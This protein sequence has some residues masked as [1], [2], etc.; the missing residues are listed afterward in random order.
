MRALSLF[1]I[2][3]TLFALAPRVRAEAPPVEFIDQAKELLVVGAC[4]DGTPPASIKPELVKAHCKSVKE[5]QAEYEKRWLSEAKPFFAAHTP[6]SGIPKSVVYPFGGGDLS[7]ALTVF[8]DA[9]EIT[10]LSLEPAGDPRTI[11][12]LDAGAMKVALSKVSTEMSALYKATFSRT[13]AMIDNMRGAQLPTQL[14][15]SL[16]ALAMHGYEP[17]S[18]R[19][20]QL[21]DAGDIHYLNADDLAK[22][23]AIKDFTRRNTELSNMELQY[24]KVG[25]KRVQT[26]RH[27]LANLDDPHL[28]KAPAALHHLEKK[29]HVSAMTK[30]ASFLLAF[31]EFSTM[32]KYL[33][34]HVDWM[35]SDATGLA[36][37]WG[38]PAGFEYETYGTFVR[39]EMDV[40]VSISPSWIAEFKAQPK[41]ELKFR[42][43]Y[44]DVQYHHNLIIMRRSAT[45]PSPTPPTPAKTSPP[46]KT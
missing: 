14:I 33:A 21:T 43:G 2:P 28:K 38:K 9:D 40:G 6:T 16:S 17:V 5:T 30:A 10:T 12:K 27:I 23:D 18:L 26:Y 41:R 8:P 45:P 4:A 44:P 22:I 15:F 46:A 37:K 39:S 35:V 3:A 29:G 32:R 34:D 36:P 24:R 20:F 25:S 13:M 19:Y 7:T 42:F 31:D 1:V 11:D